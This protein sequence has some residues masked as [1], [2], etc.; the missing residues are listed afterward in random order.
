MSEAS[1]VQAQRQEHH[2][3][4]PAEGACLDVVDCVGSRHCPLGYALVPSVRR[5]P[6]QADA[7]VV[8]QVDK[9]VVG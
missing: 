4:I 8:A 7:N 9:V 3:V 2:G 6:L 1:Y 5:D